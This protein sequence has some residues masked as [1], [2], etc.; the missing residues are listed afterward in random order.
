MRAPW[1]K[2]LATVKSTPP[3]PNTG[4]AKEAPGT[5]EKPRVSP[6]DLLRLLSYAK[7][8]QARLAV[9]LLSLLIAG[10]L[11]LAFPQVVGRLIDSAF[12]QRDSHKLNQL[13]LL[14]VG[15]FAAHS[16]F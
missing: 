4:T 1:L 14:L 5:K 3:R 8:Y 13:A 9:A 12:V 7:P 11:G 2:L 10:G 6:R 16:A 15:L